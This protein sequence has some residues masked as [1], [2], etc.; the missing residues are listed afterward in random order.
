MNDKIKELAALM[1]KATPGPWKFRHDDEKYGNI[2]GPHGRNLLNDEDCEADDPDVVL[3]I[4]MRNALPEVLEELETAKEFVKLTN[5]TNK[6][7]I[8]QRD[9]ALA[10][11]EKAEAEIERIIKEA[12]GESELALIALQ[13]ADK[14]TGQMQAE[15][16]W[17]AEQVV[18]ALGK[19]TRGEYKKPPIPQGYPLCADRATAVSAWIIAAQEAA[20]REGGGE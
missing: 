1:E 3:I 2:A 9:A 6:E 8:K 12:S 20:Q 19:T 17:L 5:E 13:A 11:A 18:D 15:R 10:R 14:R 7:A 16:D 4:A